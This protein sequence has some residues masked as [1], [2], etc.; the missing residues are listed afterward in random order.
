MIRIHRRGADRHLGLPGLL[1]DRED[2]E[3]NP[4]SRT[5]LVV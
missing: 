2:Y 4:G 1:G 5:D 3:E